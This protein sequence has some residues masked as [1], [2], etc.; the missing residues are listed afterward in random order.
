M[1][2]L[3]EI[4]R[5]IDESFQKICFLVNFISHWLCEYY[6]LFPQ[7]MLARVALT[8]TIYK[9]IFTLP[10]RTIGEIT[11]GKIVTLASYDVHRV[12]VVSAKVLCILRTYV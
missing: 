8:G 7:G 11:I 12:E 4:Y 3:C 9:K 1:S 6:N 2:I 10:L 5:I